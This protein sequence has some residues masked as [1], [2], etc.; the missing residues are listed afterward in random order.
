VQSIKHKTAYKE[1][2]FPEFRTGLYYDSS[3]V[4]HKPSEVIPGYENLSSECPERLESIIL[5]LKYNHVLE[6]LRVLPQA[7]KLPR[8]VI[9]QIHTPEY[10]ENLTSGKLEKNLDFYL[11]EDSWD[12]VV[13]AASGVASVCQQVWEGTL[14]NGFA[15]VRPPGHHARS[16]KPEGFCLLNNIAIGV[17][18]VLNP[19]TPS[20][21]PPS[22]VLVF[23]FDFHHGNG[24]QEAF[25]RTNSVMYQSIHRLEIRPNMF[26]SDDGKIQ[27]VGDGPGKGFNINLGLDYKLEGYTDADYLYAI[28]HL[29]LPI[30]N[31][32]RPELIVVA[33]GYDCAKNDP[34]G[35]DSLTPSGFYRIINLLKTIVSAN[36]KIVVALEG[37]YG[38]NTPLCVDATLKALADDIFPNYDL[39]PLQDTPSI[40][41]T[42]QVDNAITYFKRFWQFN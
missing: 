28:Q 7:N 24:I 39:E 38:R 42:T 18:N 8:I 34:V 6:G 1:E 41:M 10:L 36:G 20:V 13:N 37:G 31:Q 3:H 23:D 25:Y 35:D 29:F 33:G 17:A 27:R 14:R 15:A 12:C 30:A 11:A 26:F 5:Y 19:M 21:P 2:V 32:F 4:R 9:E 22:R 16:N 40:I